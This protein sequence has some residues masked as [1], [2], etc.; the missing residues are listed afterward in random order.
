MPPRQTCSEAAASLERER[1]GVAALEN[2]PEESGASSP[3]SQA[4]SSPGAEVQLAMVEGTRQVEESKK[5]AS[6]SQA[7]LQNGGELVA[8][9]AHELRAQKAELRAQKLAAKE[10]REAR[11]ARNQAQK[12]LHQAGIKA[13][14]EERF[15]KK[16]LATL[17]GLGLP[18]PPE[19][20]VPIP[21]P[22]TLESEGEYEN[23]SGNG[24]GNGS[25]HG[26]EEMIIFKMVKFCTFTYNLL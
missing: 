8:A 17:Q 10:A 12:Q 5:R 13:R 15:R 9:E 22:E 18:I 26:N 2:A 6:R 25:D 19:L 14:K 3:L 11:Q 1:S 7:R 20:E 16:S 24:S 4:H 23:G 21:D